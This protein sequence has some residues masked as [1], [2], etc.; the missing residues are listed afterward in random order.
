MQNFTCKENV[1]LH[2]FSCDYIFCE[3]NSQIDTFHR[4]QTGKEIVTNP[5]WLAAVYGISWR[6]GT[7]QVPS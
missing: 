3:Q 4:V 5:S 2:D 1:N 6:L 7:V